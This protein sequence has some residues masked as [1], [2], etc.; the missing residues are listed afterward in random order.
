MPPTAFFTTLD[1]VLYAVV[2]AVPIGLPAPDRVATST[3]ATIATITAYSTEPWPS[4]P[5]ARS[6]APS[7]AASIHAATYAITLLMTGRPPVLSRLLA[8]ALP[9]QRPWSGSADAALA[10]LY[11]EWAGEY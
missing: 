10:G 5:S 11:A 4:S 1:I 8:G 3:T 6:I 9:T 7:R 2:S